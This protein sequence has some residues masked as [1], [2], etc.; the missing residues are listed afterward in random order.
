KATKVDG[1]YDSD[2]KKN[3]NA[4]RFESISYIDALSRN[5][6]VMDSTSLSLCMDN[7]MPI[8]VF[9]LFQRGNIKRVIMGETVGTLVHPA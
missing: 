9:D 7:Q 6:K 8:I 3:P 5:L 2:P 4:K 1:V